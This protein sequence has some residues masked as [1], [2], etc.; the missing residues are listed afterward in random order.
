MATGDYYL[1]IDGIT[2]ESEAVGFENQIQL[3][4]WSFGGNN[5]GT[6]TLGTGLGR[7]KVSLQDFHFTMENGKASVQVFLAMCKGNHIPQ[8]ILSCRKTGGDGSPY[9]FYKVTF[10]DL[11]IS[12]F[13]TGGHEG[14]G[15][16]IEQCSFNFTKI[17]HEYFQQKADGSVSL[18]NTTSYDVK[19]VQG[20]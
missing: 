10:N 11:V 5:S 20:A 8:A 4:S 1:K 2:G 7:G 3:K 18:T 16:P 9:T 15:V 19:K 14:G 6:S 13:Q 12:S 17:T